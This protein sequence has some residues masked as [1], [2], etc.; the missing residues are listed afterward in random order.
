MKLGNILFSTLAIVFA[1]CNFTT[2]YPSDKI[3]PD[4]SQ[5][6]L[7]KYK[8]DLSQTSQASEACAIRYR[9]VRGISYDEAVI[10]FVESSEYCEGPEAALET[11]CTMYRGKKVDWLAFGL[12]DRQV[13]D[14]YCY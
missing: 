1:T 10:N 2:A 3:S 4:L 9:M 5:S 7:N 11:L 8:H 13:N 14:Q 12:G 6:D